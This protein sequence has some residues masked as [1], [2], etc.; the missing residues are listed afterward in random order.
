[1]TTARRPVKREN[2]I[3]VRRGPLEKQEARAGLLFVLPWLL[4]AAV[5]L[6]Y[7]LGM[8]LWY[9]LNNIRLTSEGMKFTFLAPVI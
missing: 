6:L 3:R 8:S 4:G 2:R 7:P 9:S 1:M 5:F